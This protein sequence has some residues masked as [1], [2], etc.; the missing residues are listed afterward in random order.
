MKILSQNIKRRMLELEGLLNSEGKNFD[1]RNKMTINMCV[2]VICRGSKTIYIGFTKRA[3][4]IRLREL[5]ADPRSHILHKKLLDNFKT[6]GKVR[7]F[8]ETQC[9]FKV[10]GFKNEKEAR[11]LEHFA[12]SI[13]NPK[14]ND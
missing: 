8:L 5:F 12:I 2:Y 1:E 4:K 3:L 14:Y 9:K 10:L 13:L 7:K 11:L 6:K